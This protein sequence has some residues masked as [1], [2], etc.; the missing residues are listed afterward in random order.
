MILRVS[1]REK[2]AM[3]VLIPGVQKSLQKKVL[4]VAVI[5]GGVDEP[6]IPILEKYFALDID[7]IGIEPVTGENFHYL[8]LNTSNDSAD[9]SLKYDLVL[10]NQ[11]LEH[12]WNV[13][14]AFLN[15]SKLLLPGGL[16]WISC[17]FSNFFHGSP[18][19]YSSGYSPDLIEK[20]G[21]YFNFKILDSGFSGSKRIYRTRHILNQWASDKQVNWPLFSYFGVS[22]SVLQKILYNFRIFPERILLALSSKTD[23]QNPYHAIET[24]ALLQLNG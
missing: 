15:I 20:L 2:I 11:V 12:L 16:A 14:N 7:F 21:S 1:L 23:Q 6:E 9:N 10:C 3:G 4:R 13:P 8:D 22:G 24:W 19:F 5:G 18:E 17:P